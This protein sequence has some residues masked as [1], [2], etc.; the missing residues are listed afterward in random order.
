MTPPLHPLLVLLPVAHGVRRGISS[1][2]FMEDICT[3]FANERI[4]AAGRKH[5]MLIPL[6]AD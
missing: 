5:Q 2:C 3:M 4:K 6:V 1:I